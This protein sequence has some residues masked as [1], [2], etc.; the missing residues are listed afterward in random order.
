MPS[1]KVYLQAARLHT[2][3]LSLSGII[4]GSFLAASRGYF[5]LR[6]LIPAL[7]TTTGFQ[8]LSNFANDYGDG[9]KGTD[10]M[11]IGPERVLQSGKMSPSRLKKVIILAAVAS[12]AS[13]VW[14]LY[15]AFGTSHLLYFVIFML[16]GL[17]SV[18]AAITYTV[19]KNAYGY[20][21]WGDLSVFLFFGLLSVAGSF[22]L[23]T[24]QWDWTVL[25][26][27]VSIGLLSTGVLHLNNMRDREPDIRSGKRTMAVFLGEERSKKYFYYLTGFSLL[28]AL[29]YSNYHY[30]SPF[31]YLFV[32]AY[33]PLVKQLVRVWQNRRPEHLNKELKILVISTFV[34]SI[35]FGAGQVL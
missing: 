5:D 26:P 8:V 2:L 29:F 14:L 25:A 13:A 7:L 21:G 28:F 10:D 1:I 17:A 9:I 11:R 6:I 22:F 4:T 27:G 35:L 19:G 34:F 32:L 20:Y 23:Y 15:E 12:L 18:Y 31:Q 33:I 30:H 3:P 16:L 24:K